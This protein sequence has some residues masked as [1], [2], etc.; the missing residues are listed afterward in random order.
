MSNVNPMLKP[1]I[2]KV[3]C[4]IGVGEGGARLQLAEQ[5]L[6]LITDGNNWENH[7]P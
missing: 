4:H 1:R 3:T 6:S 7:K 5:V 2:T